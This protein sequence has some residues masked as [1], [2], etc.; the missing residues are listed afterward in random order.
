MCKSETNNEI[1]VNSSQK[2]IESTCQEDN[3]KKRH[4]YD[5]LKE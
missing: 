4:L 5:L 3:Y 2:T 1:D